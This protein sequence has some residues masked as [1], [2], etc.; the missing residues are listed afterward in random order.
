MDI[1]QILLLW[2]ADPYMKICLVISTHLTREYEVRISLANSEGVGREGREDL[3]GRPPLLALAYRLVLAGSLGV[4][5]CMCTWVA[6]V[7]SENYE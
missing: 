4:C 5:G 7:T 3:R 2:N 1:K 6:A